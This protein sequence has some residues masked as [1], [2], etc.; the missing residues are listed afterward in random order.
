MLWNKVK[1]EP[2]KPSVR[3]LQRF[4]EHVDWLTSLA[5]DIG[6]LPSIPEEKRLQFF[7]E[8]KA[9]S[10]DKMKAL[11]YNKRVALI[12]LLVREQHLHATDSLVDLFIKKIRKLHNNSQID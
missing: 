6:D 7:Y 10:S 5:K 2:G 3:T 9:Y 8:A 4:I 11:K 12:A 1:H